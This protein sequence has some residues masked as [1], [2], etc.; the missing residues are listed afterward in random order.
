[1]GA[2]RAEFDQAS[3]E[4]LSRVCFDVVHESREAVSVKARRV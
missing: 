1:M 3:G 2:T 4:M